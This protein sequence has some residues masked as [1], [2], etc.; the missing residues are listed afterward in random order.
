[1]VAAVQRGVPHLSAEDGCSEM[2]TCVMLRFFTRLQVFSKQV[3]S[4]LC[5]LLP[6][7]QPPKAT[8]FHHSIIN[9]A[10]SDGKNGGNE[11]TKKTGRRDYSFKRKMGEGGGPSHCR[12]FNEHN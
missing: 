3:P 8:S 9:Q 2:D 12:Q 7:S 11:A 6:T 1:M 10:Q 5:L 4:P